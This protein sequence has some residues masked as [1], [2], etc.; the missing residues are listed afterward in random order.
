MRS[1]SNALR[2]ALVACATF[3]ATQP[4]WRP[5]TNAAAQSSD[6]VVRPLFDLRSPE[7]SPFPSDAFTVAD[8]NQN[9]GRRVNLPTPQDCVAHAS[10]CEDVAILNQLDGFNMQPRISLPFDGDIYPSSATSET[11][12]LVRLRDALTKRSGERQVVGINYIVWDPTAKELSFRPDNALD[13]HTTYALVVITGV[14]DVTGNPIGVADQAT[15]SSTPASPGSRRVFDEA[16]SN[17]R[18]LGAVARGLQIA[19]LSVFTTQ[20]FSHVFERM[21][22]VIAKAPAP[23]LNLKVGP[24]ATP[25][26]FDVTTLQSFTVNAHINVKDP[27]TAQPLPNAIKNLHLI[28]NS[29]GRLAFG[30]L[31]ALDFTVRPSGH[32]PMIATRTG[33][34]PPPRAMDVAFNLWLPAATQP[35][36]GWPVVM[37]GTPANANKNACSPLVSVF[38]SQGFAVIS[39]NNMG[40]GYGSLTTTT[41]TRTDGSSVTVA[42]PGSGY[43]ADG[44]GTIAVYEP[45]Y[46]PPLTRCIAAR[47]PHFRGLHLCCNWFVL[48]RRASTLIVTDSTSSTGH[49][50]ISSDSRTPRCMACSPSPTSPRFGPQHSRPLREHRLR[51]GACRRLRVPD[52]ATPSPRVPV[53]DQRARADQHRRRAGRRTT[54]QRKPAA[55]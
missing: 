25:A 10:E 39:W 2:A 19:T 16:A 26:I 51:C 53:T 49:A 54:L 1:R 36:T 23:Q 11:I 31:P 5:L 48:S 50:F 17:V 28:P 41:V 38:A 42:T 44:N 34:L 3:L 8:A 22:D 14:R 32:L 45:Q 43:D 55:A 7:R 33:T 35:S 13:Q 21:R 52:L 40:H 15:A 30:N 18:K 4:L 20:S 47:A 46:A 37:C 6:K 29:V 9:T 24:N 12:F 27:L